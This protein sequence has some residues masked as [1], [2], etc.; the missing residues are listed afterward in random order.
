M[1]EEMSEAAKK[2]LAENKEA[3]AKSDEERAAMAKGKPTPTQEEN[4]MAAVG[5]PV[6]EKE[7]DGSG[8]D[9]AQEDMK[10]KYD[11]LRASRRESQPERPATGGYATRQ[12]RAKSE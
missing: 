1:P 7:D 12:S 10:K 11:D 5:A 2:T 6:R 4:D 8:P 9:K 3:R